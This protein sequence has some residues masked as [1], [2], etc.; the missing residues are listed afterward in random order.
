MPQTDGEIALKPATDFFGIPGNPKNDLS[1]PVDASVVDLRHLDPNKPITI[2]PNALAKKEQDKQKPSG[3]PVMDCEQGRISRDRL[4]AGLPVQ[5]EAI[6]RS[7]AHL[8]AAQK[9]LG[10]AKNESR[11]VLLQGA[12]QEAKGYAEDVLTSVKALRWQ[13]EKLNG[14]DP[15]K[16]DLLIR[17]LNAVAFGGEDLYQA[18]RSSY[19]AGEEMQK[20]VVHL[21][22]QV[23]TLADKL[24]MESGIAEKVGEEL[25]GKLWGPVGE[26]GFRGAKLS[27]DLSVAVGSGILSKAEQ[28]AAQRNLDVMRTQYER[29]RQ[30]LSEIDR[31]LSEFCKVKEQAKQ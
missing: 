22:R 10:A 17:T 6:K 24:L 7:A 8:E 18:G 25:S 12:I 30:R 23:G 2:D 16:R 21:S 9:D 4:A 3:A 29:A 15:A 14:L 26:L 28:E 31:D 11:R 13:I 19:E 27:I 20:K 5:R 1:L